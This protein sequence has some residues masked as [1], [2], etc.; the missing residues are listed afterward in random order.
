MM[1]DKHYANDGKLILRWKE[2][3]IYCSQCTAYDVA[4]T[5][6]RKRAI[7]IFRGNGWKIKSGGWICEA[8]EE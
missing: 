5:K 2:Y 4:H 7:E 3:V 6:T 8:H 1:Q